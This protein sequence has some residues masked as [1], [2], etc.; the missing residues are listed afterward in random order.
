MKEFVEY[1]MNVVR[2][3]VLMLDGGSVAFVIVSCLVEF[4]IWRYMLRFYTK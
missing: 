4:L 2:V 3:M 1:L